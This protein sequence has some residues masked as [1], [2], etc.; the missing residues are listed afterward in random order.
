MLALLSADSMALRASPELIATM[1]VVDPTL[2]SRLPAAALGAPVERP[3]AP[4]A[5]RRR[6]RCLTA[7]LHG[8]QRLLQQAGD[9]LEPVGGGI[10][11]LQALPI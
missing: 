2:S 6:K 3:T 11:R 1:E 10:D 9:A 7:L 5:A 8:R 4:V